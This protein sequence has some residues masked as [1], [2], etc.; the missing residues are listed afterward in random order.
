MCRHGTYKEV[1]II[2][3]QNKKVVAVDSCI[4]AEIQDLND[5][6][7]ITL[8]CCCGHG[9]AGMPVE[10]E[11]GFGMWKG[12]IDPPHTLISEE[13]VSLAKSIGY[14]AQPYYYADGESY[15]V[16]KIYLKTGC[17]TSDDVD[18][19]HRDNNSKIKEVLNEL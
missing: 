15:G 13:S 9:Q 10:W 5:K 7:I 18:N 14:Q 1:K 2:N 11:N 12:Y 16:W 17:I 4:A 19:W 6:G 8:G 3:K